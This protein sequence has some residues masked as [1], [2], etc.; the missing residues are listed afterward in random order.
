MN[1]TLKL[2]A[3]LSYLL[4]VHAKHNAVQVD[5]LEPI[6][7]HHLIDLYHV[8]REQAHLVLVNGVFI[9]PEERDQVDRLK[10]GDVI[11]IWP[12]VAGG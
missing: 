2:Y 7:I 4:P 1:I 6:S 12:P 11:A 3:N 10:Q 5:L 9:N 8:P